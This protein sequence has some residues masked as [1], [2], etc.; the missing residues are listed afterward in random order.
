MKYEHDRCKDCRYQFV[1]GEESPCEECSQ[2]YTDLW[3]PK[4]KELTQ[5]NVIDALHDKFKERRAL[6]IDEIE[7]LIREVFK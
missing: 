6:S 2:Y 7:Y 3:A 4:K 5:Q 1:V